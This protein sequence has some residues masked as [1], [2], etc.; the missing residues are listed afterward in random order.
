MHDLAVNKAGRNRD[1][2][3]ELEAPQSWELLELL[4]MDTARSRI[5]EYENAII[6]QGQFASGI[7][8]RNEMQ[9]FRRLPPG[10]VQK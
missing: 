6:A 7:E 2:E 10:S 9:E 1:N 3:N 8:G 5:S 4:V